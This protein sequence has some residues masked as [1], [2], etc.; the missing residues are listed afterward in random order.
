MIDQKAHDFSTIK[1]IFLNWLF[2]KRERIY[3]EYS[4]VDGFSHGEHRYDILEAKVRYHNIECSFLF[5]YNEKQR[6]CSLSSQYYL[7]LENQLCLEFLFFHE[8]IPMDEYVEHTNE[9]CAYLDQF[10]SCTNLIMDDYS[11]VDWA[12][13]LTIPS[14]EHYFQNIDSSSSS[15]NKTTLKQD[16]PIIIFN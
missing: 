11:S 13:N 6:T 5:T 12:S 2:H 15:F 1:K 16:K 3:R 14:M 10:V 4:G 8:M 9:I 7:F